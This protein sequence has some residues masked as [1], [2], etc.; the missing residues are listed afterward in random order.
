MPKR[1]LTDSAVKHLPAPESGQTDYFDLLLPAFG[2][3]VSYAG[4]RSFFV[5]TRRAGS[6]RVMRLTLGRYPVISL[7]DARN[8][9]REVLDRASRGVD[10]RS[11][12]VEDKA[13]RNGVTFGEV[14]DDFLALQTE[15]AERANPL[16][17]GVLRPSTLR[18]YRRMLTVVGASLRP[19][20]MDEI[21]RRDVK[22]IIDDLENSGRLATADQAV[23]YLGRLFRWSVEEEII[24]RSPMEGIRG[25]RR[26]KSRERVLSLEELGDVW[27]AL[28]TLSYPFGPLFRVLLL[29]GQRR[30]EVTGMRWSELTD[31]SASPVW[32]LPAD[33]TKNKLPH[34][35]PIAPMVQAIIDQCPRHNNLVFSST[36]GVLSG[37]GKAK[38][39]LDL[40]IAHVRRERGAN[41]EMA[42]WVLHDFR[43]SMSTHMHE[44]LGVEPHV[45]EAVL[46]HIS[47]TKAGVAGVYNRS[48]YEPEK[49]RALSSW[50]DHINAIV[51]GQTATVVPLKLGA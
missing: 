37:H 46:N 13:I 10:P 41:N 43:R 23:A 48:R 8:M 36:G 12:V 38:T 45:V 22:R 9:A 18:D 2:V 49:R 4:T 34:I 17:K 1:K 14:A 29:T 40:A 7:A 27:K 47:G 20:R 30:G 51:S 11:R 25:R 26:L 21:G 32:E 5:M 39:A 3:R 19:L 50:A 31:W 42:A 44:R 35:V 24:L 28:D 33:R 6:S 16:D 15:R